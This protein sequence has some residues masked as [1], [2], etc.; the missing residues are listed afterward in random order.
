MRGGKVRNNL[1][2]KTKKT[3]KID[4]A[5]LY[6]CVLMLSQITYVLTLVDMYMH[7]YVDCTGVKL[8][9]INHCVVICNLD[10]S[11]PELCMY[12][13]SCSTTICA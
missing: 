13:S 10:V 12:V 11:L 3:V 8:I 5:V 7:T 9:C 6:V 2:L 4:A 1:S